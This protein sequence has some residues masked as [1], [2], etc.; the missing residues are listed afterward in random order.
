[1]II[2]SLG[3]GLGNQMFQYAFARKMQKITGDDELIFSTYQLKG[4]GNG[5]RILFNLNIDDRISFCDE[6]KEQSVKELHT[7]IRKRISTR[8]KIGHFIPH[9]TDR[10]LKKLSRRGIYTT[11]AMYGV[12]DF[13][14]PD[15]PARYVFG[16]FQTHRYW[17][18][19]IPQIVEELR[20][21][22]APSEANLAM[23]EEMRSCE[24]VCVH[25]RRGDYLAPEFAHL[26]VCGEDYYMEAMRRMKAMKP[27]A[28]FFIFSNNHKELMWIKENYKLDEFNVRFVDLK[29]PDYEELRLMYNCKNFIIANST[30]SWW[31][32]LLAYND[33]KIVMAPS[34][35]NREL[36]ADG[37]YMKGWEIIPVK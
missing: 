37:I 3:G 23:T 30:Y 29:N 4:T 14:Y 8:N 13:E 12:Q 25:I 35:W 2:L 10:Y 11:S 1:M 32:Q 33:D 27:D 24:S 36:S 6:G 21:K 9:T 18:D 28:V 5:E 17:E 22:R 34:I 20:V 7:A 19:M 26:N 31:A 16:G 15:V